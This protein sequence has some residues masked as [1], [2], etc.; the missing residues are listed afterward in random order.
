MKPSQSRFDVSEP[1]NLT[2]L[3]DFY[4]LTMGNGYLDNG[5]GDKVATFDMYFRTIPDNGGYGVMAGV[6]QLLDYISEL[7][8]TDNDIHYLE[9]LDHF[10]PEFIDFLR[11]FKFTCDVYAIPEGT[12]VFPNEPL[13]TVRG[14][15]LQ[16]QL[17]ETMVLLTINHQTLI[18][19]KSSRIVRAADGRGVME[20]GSRRAQGYDGA[21]YGARAAMIAGCI[22]TSNTLAGLQFDVPVLGTMAH[23]WIQMFDSEYE[24]FAAYARTYPKNCLL[25]VDTYNTL[26]SGIPN[27]IKVFDKII[28]PMGYR[29]TGIRIDSGDIT[30]LTKEARHML[31]A[32]GYQDV[33]ILVSNSLDE[34]I[35][36]DVLSQG[37][38]IDSFGVGERLITA[39]SEPVFGG[40]YKL[41]AVDDQFGVPQPKIKLSDNE[42][43]ITTPAFK[44][45]Y[46][47]FSKRDDMALADVIC[48]HDE[49]INES[50]PYEIF[51][52]IY[53]WKKKTLRNYYVKELQIPIFLQGKQVY[54]SPS[55]KEISAYSK[56]ELSKLW[57]EVKR[58][59]NPHGY[60]ID[61][62]HRLWQTKQ[63]LLNELTDEFARLEMEEEQ[64]EEAASISR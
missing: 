43:K 33:K 19:T 13:V 64:K 21:I 48:H 34:F 57:A 53:T 16:A 37:A 59:E 12:P 63:D 18:T 29:P 52:P 28:V 7:K 56:H 2:M 3:T 31:D 27:A 36:R 6:A 23:S 38:Q 14:P 22:G 55:V 61:L 45:L 5:M 24:A 20:F 25:L 10:K 39:R 1:R 30:Y 62:S 4:E 44:K 32:A 46:R 40:V 15:I 51:D 42:E 47:F 9:S 58:L 35:I 49:V 41:V 26:R 17:L 11:H 60:Y 54:E 50:K 8:F